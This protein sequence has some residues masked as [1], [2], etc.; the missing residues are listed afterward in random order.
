[1]SEYEFVSVILAAIAALISLVVWNGQ[2]KLQQESLDMQKATA[3]L[4][5]K[6][7]EVLMRED[8]VKNSARLKLALV[9][10]GNGYKFVIT[11]VSDV[12]AQDVNF[13]LL[14]DSNR[15]SPLIESDLAEKLPA[16]KLQSGCE[17]SLIAAISKSTP[18]AYNARLS[19]RN[20]NGEIV[21]DDTYVAL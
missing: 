4:A 6:Q 20:P 15:H 13:E 17:L 1:M 19:W 3:E 5:K 18:M 10:K 11:N 14:L 12:D 21:Y 2:R 7:L 16:P 8:Q 9:S